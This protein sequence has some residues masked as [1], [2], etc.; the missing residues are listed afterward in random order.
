MKFIAIVSALAAALTSTQVEAAK[1]VAAA[2]DLTPGSTACALGDISPVATA[3]RGFYAG[4]LNGGSSAMRRD[5][6]QALTALTGASYTGATLTWLEDVDISRG[7]VVDFD[8][9]LFGATVVSFHVGA[10]RGQSTGVG[11]Q[12]TAFYMFDAGSLLGGLDTITFNRAGL[13]NARLYSTGSPGAVPEPAT[14]A[15]MI[16]GFGAVGGG[17]RRT[18]RAERSAFTAA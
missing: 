12:A 3:C 7:G 13:S 16:G 11:Y 2:Q 14:W 17:M 1:P 4:N 5:S 10:A 18:R 9:P 15:M 6:A 8:T